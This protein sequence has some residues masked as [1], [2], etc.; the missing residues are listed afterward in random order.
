MRHRGPDL[1][2][3]WFD[4]TAGIGLGHCRLSILELSSAGDQPMV[5]HSGQY[6]LVYNGEVYNHLTP[7]ENLKAEGA[8][9]EWMGHSDTE[10]LLAAISAWGLVKTLQRSR[11]MF[12]LGLWN[13][14]TKSLLL[15]RDRVGEKPLYYGMA[16]SSFVF[17]SELRAIRQI[18]GVAGSRIRLIRSVGVDVKL[19]RLS[20]EPCGASI[21]MLPSRLLWDK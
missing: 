8:E 13:R 6:V 20:D 1:E 12:A 2:G 16:G 7:R 18:C 3:I 17:A 4:T 21:D 15:A 11:G 9:P 5:S 10:T 19:F 14:K